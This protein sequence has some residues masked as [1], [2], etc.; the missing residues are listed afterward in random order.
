MAVGAESFRKS[1]NLGRATALAIQTTQHVMESFVN[2][3]KTIECEEI[4][5]TDFSN[6]WSFTKYLLSGKFVHC[7]KLTGKWAPEA[8]QAAEESFAK[9]SNQSEEAISCASEVVKQMGGTEEEQAMVA[10][11][12][13][14]LGLS[15]SACGVLAAIIWK[16]ILELVKKEN[17]KYSLS[18][19]VTENILKKFYETTDYKMECHEICGQRFNS[20]DEHSEFIKNGG[21]NKLIKKLA[22]L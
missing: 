12:A 2:R 7:F 3:T 1:E 13:G 10:G 18:D 15:G 16:T 6:K 4:T 17:W 5:K 8:I 9:F 19:P 11:F 22:E 20:I 21:C 14:G